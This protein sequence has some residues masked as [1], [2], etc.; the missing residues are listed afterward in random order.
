MLVPLCVNVIVAVG[1]EKAT[2]QVRDECWT[3][4]LL[5]NTTKLP[6]MEGKVIFILKEG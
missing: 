2:V 4:Q 1:D 3:G 6:P 5:V